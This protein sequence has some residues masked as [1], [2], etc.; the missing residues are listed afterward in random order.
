M[1][2][3][4]IS[5]LPPPLKI[6]F[7]LL[8]N[9]FGNRTKSNEIR[10]L[11][12]N[13]TTRKDAECNIVGVVGVAQVSFTSGFYSPQHS[14]HCDWQEFF[15]SDRM[16]LRPQNTIEKWRQWQM[17]C[18]NWWIPQM[19]QVSKVCRNICIT[20]YSLILTSIIHSL[21]NWCEW[22]CK[23]MEWK[24][25]RNNW[26]FQRWGIQQTIRWVFRRYPLCVISH[27]YLKLT[28]WSI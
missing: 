13:A 16:W 9:F 19:L 10:Y 20:F 5:D 12:V 22:Q 27:F 18:V 23:R 1:N 6:V 4:F 15:H 24:D 3:G 21:W 25:C 7:H 28:I 8:N 26:F 2:F 14:V 11:L 17:N